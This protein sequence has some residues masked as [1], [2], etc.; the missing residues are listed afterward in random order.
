MQG[1]RYLLAKQSSWFVLEHCLSYSLCAT[2]LHKFLRGQ[3][4]SIPSLVW[5][6]VFMLSSTSLSPHN[7]GNTKADQIYLIPEG[8]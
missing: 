7:F 5:V 6:L 3:S 1:A 2:L 8:I 4:L